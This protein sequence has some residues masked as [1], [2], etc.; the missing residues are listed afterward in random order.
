MASNPVNIADMLEAI[1]TGAVPGGFSP[2]RAVY[3]FPTLS[4][5]NSRGKRMLWTISVRL[6]RHGSSVPMA[7]EMLRP[8]AELGPDL[9]AVIGVQSLQEGGKIRPTKPTLVTAGKNLGKRNATNQLTQALR[10]ALGLYNRHSRHV[11]NAVGPPRSAAPAPAKGR[12]AR[13]RAASANGTFDPAPP[14]MLVQKLGATR[15]ATLTDADFAAGVIVQRKFNGVHVVAHAAEGDPEEL[16]TYSRTSSTYPGQHQLAAE[17]LPMLSKAPPIGAEFGVPE[18]ASPAIRAAYS[19]PKHAVYLDGELYLHGRSL[20]WISGQA[21]KDID[22]GS[23]EFQVFD[24]FFPRAKAAGDDMTS[25]NRQAYLDALFRAADA[26]GLA[27]P[28]IVRVQS[29]PAASSAEVQALAGQFVREKYEG[30]IARKS[31]GRYR[32]SYNNYHAAALIKIKPKYDDEFPVVGFTQGTKG[33]AVGA[34]IW[35]CEVQK[36]VDPRD[37]TFN[38]VPK[39]LTDRQRQSL[40]KCLG[41]YVEGPGGKKLTRFDRDVKGLLLTVEY[42][43]TSAK[44]GKPLQAKALAFRTYEGGPQNDPIRKLMLECGAL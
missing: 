44:T 39:N 5:S 24:V 8:G 36:P 42:A 32:Y 30:A 1:R 22:E 13:G 17:L 40:F 9:V 27:H 23:L 29:F 7:E 28:H 15:E 4:Y 35:I 26:A 14:P 2:D 16:V 43:E 12:A 3:T 19:D 31:D 37:K 18:T 20:N 6:D 41:Q 10:D 33:K 21:R 34:L 38:V 11:G 25:R